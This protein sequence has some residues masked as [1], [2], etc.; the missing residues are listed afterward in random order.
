[1]HLPLDTDRIQA[2]FFATRLATQTDALIWPT[3]T[4]GHYPAFVEYAGSTS[5]S[6]ATFEAMVAEIASD[7]LTHGCRALFVLDTGISTR[8]PVARALARLE[9]ANVLHVNIHDGPRYGLV[10]RQ[11]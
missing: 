3:F 8:D 7:I 6:G 2:E 5:L 9:V 10:A 4:Y 1:L 11:L